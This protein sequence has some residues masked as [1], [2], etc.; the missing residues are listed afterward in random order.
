MQFSVLS[1]SRLDVRVAVSGTR[2][3][4]SG[5]KF[6]KQAQSRTARMAVH[7]LQ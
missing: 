6:N 4:P 2:L 5:N 3:N 1:F 7:A